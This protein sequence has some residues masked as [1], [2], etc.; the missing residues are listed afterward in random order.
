M[1]AQFAPADHII[2]LGPGPGIHGGEVVVQGELETILDCP[3][4]L[5][6]LY[7]SGQR[8]I[9]LP[10]QRR[11]LNG[12]FLSITGASENNLRNIDVDIPIGV[13]ICITG[14]S[15]SG[16]STL[17]NEILYEAA[18]F[19]LPRQPHPLRRTRRTRR[20]PASK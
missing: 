12:T 5:T 14:A 20:T 18:L 6:G 10:K 8:E 7:M 11:D 13:F 17:V 2:E 9:R 15:G 3:E 16:K 19:P 4:S 1:R